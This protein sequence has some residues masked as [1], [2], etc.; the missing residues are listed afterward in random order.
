MSFTESRGGCE[1][2]ASATDVNQTVW[3]SVGHLLGFLLSWPLSLEKLL[4]ATV[5]LPATD[6]PSY[7][8]DSSTSAN[9]RQNT[10]VSVSY[11][12]I[13]LRYIVKRD[14]QIYTEFTIR[15]LIVYVKLISI[16]FWFSTKLLETINKCYFCY[17]CNSFFICVM[18]RW[19][20]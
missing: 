20:Q 6:R 17:Y 16:L 5:S 8:S 18:Y 12:T 3:A 14:K 7:T 1:R 10:S 13:I 15:Y 2:S 4:R 9:V 19:Y 11:K